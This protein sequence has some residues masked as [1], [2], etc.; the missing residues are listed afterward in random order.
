[1]KLSGQNYK[2]YIKCLTNYNLAGNYFY[3]IYI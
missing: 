3:N 2:E 1:M